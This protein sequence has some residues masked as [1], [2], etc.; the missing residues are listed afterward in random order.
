MRRLRRYHFYMGVFFTPA[1]LLFALSGALQT[2]R[3]QEAGGYGGTP[4]GWIVWMAAI[5][6]D[7][8]LPREKAAGPYRHAPAPAAPAKPA[9][10]RAPRPSPLPLKVFVVLLSAGLIASALLG[11][12]IALNGA[13]TR[14]MSVLMLIAGTILPLILLLI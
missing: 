5:H 13:A 6:K 2:F 7:Q 12:A 8:A 10:K 11:V 4:P 1:I 9:V 3:L 14:R